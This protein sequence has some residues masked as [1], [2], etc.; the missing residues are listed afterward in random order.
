MPSALKTVTV[1]IPTRDEE[2][3]IGEIVDAVRPHGDDVLVVDGHSRDRTREIAAAHGATVILDNRKGQGE[4]LV[5][6]GAVMHAKANL[7]KIRALCGKAACPEGNVLAAAI[8]KLLKDADLRRAY[9]EAGRQ[10]VARQFDVE[11]LITGTL[12]AYRRLGV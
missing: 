2:G 7:G 4:A 5:M 8:V 11:H 12:A 3:L 6:K 1:V 9:G 10:R